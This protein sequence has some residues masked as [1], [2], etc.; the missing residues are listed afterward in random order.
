MKISEY[1]TEG[2]SPVV[3]HSTSFLNAYS[4]LKS[5]EF[6]LSPTLVDNEEAKHQ[7]D[8]YFL[9]TS[10]HVL[11][12]FHSN[13]FG[14]VLFV[15]DGNKL[16]HNY[17]GSAV[18]YF[19][20]D[21]D[22]DVDEAEDRIFSSKPVIP[23]ATK[24]IKEVHVSSTNS[25]HRVLVRKIFAEAKLKNIPV[26][27]YQDQ[28][29]WQ[30]LRRNKAVTELPTKYKKAKATK[31]QFK[32]TDYEKRKARSSW[33]EMSKMF[34]PWIELIYKKNYEDLSDKAKKLADNARIPRRVEYALRS[35]LAR[36]QGRG[37][38]T[39]HHN[40]FKIMKRNK[41]KNF[42]ELAEFLVNKWHPEQ[43]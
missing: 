15:L 30:Q 35:G 39:A 4:I 37:I 3:Y 16:S 29:Y 42:D 33:D 21:E 28:R 14:G 13:G 23:N 41:I 40:L 11:G 18:D 26:Y 5:D 32:P 7:K 31:Q 6:R 12:S 10:R 17:K 36:S 22:D 25:E 38:E 8:F 20:Q 1:I 2:I 27:F 9:S 34:K 24:Y 19:Y 43:K